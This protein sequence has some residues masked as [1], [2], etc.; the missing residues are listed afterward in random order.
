MGNVGYVRLGLEQLALSMDTLPVLQEA[1]LQ[2]S[3]LQFLQ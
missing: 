1:S 2:R 3:V